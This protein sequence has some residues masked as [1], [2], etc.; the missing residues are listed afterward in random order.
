MDVKGA[1]ST[2]ANTNT[3]G[4]EKLS[5]AEHAS[6]RGPQGVSGTYSKP[7]GH[8]HAAGTGLPD[9]PTGEPKNQSNSK[10]GEAPSYVNTNVGKFGSGGVHGKNLTELGP[11]EKF[12][13]EEQGAKQEMLDPGRRAADDIQKENA[14]TDTNAAM[15]EGGGDD[16]NPYSALKVE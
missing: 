8:S 2:F 13:K 7:H 14:R 15:G 10:A 1:N 11:D 3:S 6:D 9:K 4:A 16:K 12:F 5:A